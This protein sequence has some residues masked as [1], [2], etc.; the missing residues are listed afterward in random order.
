MTRQLTSKNSM[1]ENANK[2]SSPTEAAKPAVKQRDA[3]V[4]RQRLLDAALASFSTQ[5]FEASSTRQI[6]TRA[7]VKRGLIGYHFGS[8]KELWI[9][10]A[11][12]IMTIAEQELTA[13]LSSIEHVDPDSRL[14]F[15]IRA[16]V[17]FCARHPE[18]NRLM[19][20]E[21]MDPDWRLQWL[22]D[23]V[24]KRWYNQVC[25]LF[26]EAAAKSNAPKMSAHHFYYTVTGAATL[27]FSNAAEAEALSNQNPLSPEMVEAHAEALANLFV[28]TGN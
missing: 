26:N 3:D 19:I 5:G 4:T 28:P 6:E 9:A 24:V 11:D 15:F 25:Y 2:Q 13:G 27:M 17:A 20:Q 16:Y 22:L 21:G 10:A 23:R 1:A 12:Y 7:G 14:R 18:V 8:K